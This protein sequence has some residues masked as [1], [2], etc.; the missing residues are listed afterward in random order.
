MNQ[1]LTLAFQKEMTAAKAQYEKAQYSK[2]FY[3]LER[4]HILGQSFI[5]P[6]TQSHWWMLKLGYKTG[7]V[8]EVLGQTARIIASVIFSKIWVPKGNTGGT[9]VSPIKPM[10]IPADLAEYLK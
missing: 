8:K 6:H 10:P 2:S 1:K 4:A 7:S 3:H 5:I 9:N